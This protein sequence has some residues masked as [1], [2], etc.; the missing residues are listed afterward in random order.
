MA[1]TYPEGEAFFLRSALDSPD[2]TG[3]Q[4]SDPKQFYSHIMVEYIWNRWS[5]HGS[6]NTKGNSHPRAE[7]KVVQGT[8]W[9]STYY[10]AWAHLPFSYGPEPSDIKRRVQHQLCTNGDRFVSL[11][12]GGSNEVNPGLE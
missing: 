2:R 6:S 5:D 8:G 7:Y 4:A 11:E 9:W 1:L 12:K 10:G 3:Y